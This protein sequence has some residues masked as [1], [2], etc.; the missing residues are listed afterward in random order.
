[1][2]RIASLVL[3]V[4]LAVT[5]AAVV[6]A[7]QAQQS[8]LKVSAIPDEAPTELQRKFTPLGEYLEKETGMKVQFIPVTDYAAVVEGLATASST[9]PGSAASPSCRRSCAPTAARC[10]S[11]SAPRTRVFTS[12]FITSQPDVKT[13]ADLK[14]KTF[15]FGAPSSTSGSLMPRYYL[16]Q[17]GIDPERDFKRVAFSGAH[18]ATA[19]FVAVRQG[20]R[21]RAQR[22]GEGQA[23]RGEEV[24]TPRC[25]C[26][27]SRRPTST[28]TGRCAAISTRRSSRSSPTRSSSSIP[29]SRSRRRSSTCSARRSS[30]RPRRR[31]TTA[32]SGGALRGPA[33]VT[34][35]RG[36]RELPAAT[37][38]R[39][40]TPTASAR[41]RGV[42]A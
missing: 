22:L 25:A 33:E 4:G 28:T 38:F 1:M 17:A 39:S 26:S 31:T 13:L 36:V 19:A 8:V 21:R 29:A 35:G 9:S 42:S 2:S 11:S 20:R 32:S 5:L 24:D 14:G 18:D 23:G 40:S 7:A 30:S 37:A 41:S 27:R 16:L 3:Q 12:R 15:A 34:C 10:R 6:G